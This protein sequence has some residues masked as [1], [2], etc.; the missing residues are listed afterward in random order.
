MLKYQ[1]LDLMYQNTFMILEHKIKLFLYQNIN[2]LNFK[3]KL[4]F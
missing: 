2:F 1:L 3:M 4:T